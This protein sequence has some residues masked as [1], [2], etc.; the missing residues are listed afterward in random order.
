MKMRMRM[1]MSKLMT[2]LGIAAV[3]FIAGC[4][5]DGDWN[6]PNRPANFKASTVQIPLSGS[7][8]LTR[9]LQELR[10]H[11]LPLLMLAPEHST[12]L[13]PKALSLQVVL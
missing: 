6:N 1:R 4:N 10:L 5:K 7:V 8:P 3:V 12:F 2:T 13:Q 11:L 9:L